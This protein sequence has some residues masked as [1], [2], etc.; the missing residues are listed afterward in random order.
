M[1]GK[2][3]RLVELVTSYSLVVRMREGVELVYS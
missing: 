3:G 1:V 2:E